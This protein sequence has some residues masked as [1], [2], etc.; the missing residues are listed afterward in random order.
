MSR[1]ATTRYYRFLELIPGVLTWSTFFFGIAFSFVRP[2]W[3]IYFIIV[4]DLYWFFRFGYLISHLLMSFHRYRQDAKRNWK[5]IARRAKGWGKVYHMVFLPN[6]TEEFVVMQT[7]LDAMLSCSFPASRIIV[8]LALEERFHQ[9]KEIAESV[10]ARYGDKFFKVLV[11]WHPDN[12]P[13]EIRGKGANLHHAGHVAK[14]FIAT[15]SI[16]HDDVI[17]SSF[18]VDTNVNPDYFCYLTAKYLEEDRPTRFSYQPV[19]LF[20]NNI[21]DAPALT[22]IAANSTSFWLMTEQTRPEAMFTFSSHAMS[23]TAL[24]DVGFWQKD[25]VTEDSR[26]F[27]QCFLYYDGDYQVKPLYI[28]VSMDAV[29]GATFW[30][31]MKNIYKQQRRWAWGVEHFPYMM[32]H[33][34]GNKKI[35]FIKKFRYTFKLTEGMYSWATAPLLILVLGRLPL[36]TIN[37]NDASSIV[38]QNAPYVL[39]AIMNVGLIGLVFSGVLSTLLLPK[40]P[41]RQPRYCVLVMALQW[42]L[43]PLVMIIFGSFPATD[44]QTRLLVGKELGFWVT[45]KSRK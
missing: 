39:S 41:D 3:V 45:P 28:P 32:R 4:F 2:L 19:P 21:W 43:F 14:K 37:A 6:A 9:N 10:V 29:Q 25:I 1:Y 36:W 5:S 44:A 30:E 11:S 16:T 24:V 42:I 23:F 17:V 35:P 18:D 15:T 31:G 33:F 34:R 27:L 20:N 7:T 26:I 12:L 22:R 13:G 40:R 8:V 38:A